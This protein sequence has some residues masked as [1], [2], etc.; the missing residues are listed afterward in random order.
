MS[1]YIELIKQKNGIRNFWKE[2]GKKNIVRNNI[3]NL[4]SY[5][6]P[7]MQNKKQTCMSNN[8]NYDTFSETQGP[9]DEALNKVNSVKIRTTKVSGFDFRHSDF[10]RVLWLR[11]RTGLNRR[12]IVSL[13]ILNIYARNL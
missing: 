1:I 12:Q 13:Q 5:C 11:R 2:S 4:L 8:S 7:N 9:W 10:C 6:K 3:T